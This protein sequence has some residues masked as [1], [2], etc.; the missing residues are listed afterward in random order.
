V[1][2]DALKAE[3]ED[4]G[5]TCVLSLRTGVPDQV[6]VQEARKRKADLVVMGT[7]GRT[8]IPHL[9]LG[10]VAERVVR[11]SSC[12]VLTVRGKASRDKGRRARSRRKGAR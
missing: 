4:A 8:G 6:I 1:R 5:V 11:A 7:H 3:I 12:P 9:V 10:S 2:L